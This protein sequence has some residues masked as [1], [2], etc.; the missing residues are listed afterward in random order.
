MN[1][2][3]NF[4]RFSA[5]LASA[6]AVAA[7]A[8]PT[9]AQDLPTSQPPMLLITREQVKVG[10]DADHAKI[11]AGWPAAYTKAKFPDYYI[12]ITSITGQPQA[13]FI[14]PFA[15]NAAVGE[16]LERQSADATLDTELARLSKADAE[17]LDGLNVIQAR[18]RP[19]L[20]QGAFPDMVSRRYYAITVIQMRPGRGDALDSILKITNAAATRAGVSNSFRVY[21]IVAGMPSPTF[22]VFTTAASM[23][24]FD[25][26]AANGM[27]VNAALTAEE[28]AALL[29][30]RT[31]GIA[32]TVTQRFRIN[33]AMSYVSAAT[34]E[35]DPKFWG[36][37]K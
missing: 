8:T 4:R 28:Q 24:E 35:K 9:V 29:K 6:I 15:S 1:H 13:W 12:A 14:A 26:N 34:R 21:Q 33:P 10:R 19:E 2:R 27:K 18:A 5:M 3:P 20:S 16:S 32:S 37:K 25:V 11:E 7:V 22:L 36:L 30:Y 17:V 23:A 31:D